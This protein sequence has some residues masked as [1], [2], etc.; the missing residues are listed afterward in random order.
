MADPQRVKRSLAFSLLSTTVL[1]SLVKQLTHWIDFC[2]VVR[3][4][5]KVRG[6]NLNATE[7]SCGQQKIS[8]LF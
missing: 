6:E 1:G 4:P 8:T 5:D 3:Q 7:V 2:L